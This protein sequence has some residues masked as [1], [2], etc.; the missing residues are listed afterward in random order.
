MKRAGPKDATGLVAVFAAKSKQ[1]YPLGSSPHPPPPPHTETFPFAR[2]VLL[3]ISQAV[4]RLM[5]GQLTVGCI[6]TTKN[7]DSLLRSPTVYLQ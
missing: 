7:K 6:V 1:G 2:K 4:S 3:I 5:P